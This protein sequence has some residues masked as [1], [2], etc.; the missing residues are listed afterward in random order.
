MDTAFEPLTT[1]GCGLIRAETQVREAHKY[2]FLFCKADK[3][4]ET[5]EMTVLWLHLNGL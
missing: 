1:T 4:G 2:S 5:F 3:I